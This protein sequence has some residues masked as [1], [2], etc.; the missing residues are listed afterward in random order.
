MITFAVKFEVGGIDDPCAGSPKNHVLS[1]SPGDLEIIIKKS[2][3][4]GWKGFPPFAQVLDREIR[5][6]DFRTY[7]VLHTGSVGQILFSVSAA[8]HTGERQYRGQQENEIPTNCHAQE[9]FGILGNDGSDSS[10]TTH[11]NLS[12][13]KITFCGAKGVGSSS[14]AIVTSIISESF[15]SSRNK[16]VPQHPAKERI[17]FA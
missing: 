9:V 2:S 3:R 15:V 7:A 5:K 10:I 13:R 8:R 14:D 17:R 1:F 12:S 4:I 16:C 6:V 11:G